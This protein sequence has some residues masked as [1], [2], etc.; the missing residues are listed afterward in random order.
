MPIPSFDEAARVWSASLGGT[1]EEQKLRTTIIIRL[2]SEI[3][4][5]D[6]F[7][8]KGNTTLRITHPE[9]RVKKAFLQDREI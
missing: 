3:E 7:K 8:S 5:I 9:G 2:R 1:I 6:R 4:Y